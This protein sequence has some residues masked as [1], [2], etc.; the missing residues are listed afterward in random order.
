MT[1][2]FDPAHF[3]ITINIS[4]KDIIIIIIKT[5]DF[6]N[7]SLNLHLFRKSDKQNF[8]FSKTIYSLY[9]FL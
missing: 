2:D 5:A 3:K 6:S 7:E 9:S 4:I 1:I 8:F